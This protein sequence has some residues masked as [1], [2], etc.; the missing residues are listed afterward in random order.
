MECAHALPSDDDLPSDAP[1]AC[2]TL[3]ANAALSHQDSDTE[4]MQDLP[5]DNENESEGQM[6]QGQAN[7]Q[8]EP[9][10]F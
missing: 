4:W 9:S 10:T 5:S 1:V 8:G 3:A 6:S 2:D 7:E